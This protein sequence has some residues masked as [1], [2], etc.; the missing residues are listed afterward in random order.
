MPPS[1][2]NRHSR[3]ICRFGLFLPV[4]EPSKMFVVRQICKRFGATDALV[5]VDAAFRPGEVTV[6][7]GCSGAGK[8]TLLRIVT[9]VETPDS[10][11]VLFDDRDVT[12]WPAHDRDVGLV[13]QDCALYPGQTIAANLALALRRSKLTSTQRRDRIRQT[14]QECAIAALA[15]RLPNELSGGQLQRAALAKA[16]VRRPR[17]LALDEPFSQLDIRTKTPLLQWIDEANRRYEMTI[18]MVSHDPADAMRLGHSVVILQAGR[19]LDTG[20]PSELYRRPRTRDS[21]SLMGMFGMN[22]LPAVDAVP[23]LPRV[24]KPPVARYVGFRPE[25]FVATSSSVQGAAEARAEGT[26]DRSLQPVGW[27]LHGS[28]GHVRDIGAGVLVHARVLDHPVTLPLPAGTL[29]VGDTIHGFVPLDRL[30]WVN[31]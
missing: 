3:T 28:I 14:L 27:T 4:V 23:Q 13:S 21:G 31:E 2:H 30:C 7:L 18:V 17:I 1:V 15:D 9:G 26:P 12:R 5:G 22:W 11:Q 8:S 20:T 6:V 16:M 25:H 10:G 24:P 19:V 29:V